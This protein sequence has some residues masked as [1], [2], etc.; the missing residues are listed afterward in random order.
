MSDCRCSVFEGLFCPLSF[1][2]DDD[3]VQQLSISLFH[4]MMLV[5]EEVGEKPLQALLHQS[6]FPL[7]F[8]LH[9]E[10]ETWHR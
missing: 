2:Q 6:M 5:V 10:E 1:Q 8:H 9:D 3:N 7:F 4:D